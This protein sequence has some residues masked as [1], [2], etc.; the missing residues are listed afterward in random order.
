MGQRQVSFS[1]IIVLQPLLQKDYASANEMVVVTHLM[2]HL[3]VDIRTPD[4]RSNM[5]E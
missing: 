5:A 1:P 2:P 4:I 3:L